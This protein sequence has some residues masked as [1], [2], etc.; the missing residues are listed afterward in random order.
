MKTHVALLLAALAAP[1]TDP[2]LRYPATSKGDVVDD[3]SGS[4]VADPYRWLED[5]E[6]PATREWIEAQNAVTFRYLD[7]I[8][9]RVAIK[10]RLTG[11]WNYPRT[12]I[13]V[14]EAGSLF[15]LRNS[16]LERQSRLLMRKALADEPKLLIDPNALSPDGSVAFAQWAVSPDGRYLAYGLAQGGADWQTVHVREIATG[17]ELPDRIEWFRFSGISWTKDGAGFFYARYPEPPKG[18][19]LRAPLEPLVHPCVG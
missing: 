7:A 11:L 14:R 13:P 15:C 10:K 3:Y 6:A 1:A 4:K 16:G 8:P 18:Q 2:L 19:E 12:G 5:L 9:G 17:R